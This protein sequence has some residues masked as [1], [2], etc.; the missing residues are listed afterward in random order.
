MVDRACDS[1]TFSEI[2]FPQPP[3]RFNQFRKLHIFQY[4]HIANVI[5]PEEYSMFKNGIRTGLYPEPGYYEIDINI[6]FIIQFFR[7]F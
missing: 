1:I 2:E 6:W 4:C 3:F 5:I 7:P